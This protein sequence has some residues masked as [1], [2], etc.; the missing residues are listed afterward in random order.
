MSNLRNQDQSKAAKKKY[1]HP[2]IDI[3]FNDEPLSREQIGEKL[4]IKSDRSIR[5]IIA[6]CSM[7]YPIIATSDK[8]GY[9]RAKNMELLN[10]EELEKEIQEVEHQIN[11]LKSRVACL[12]KRM[13]PLVAWVS[14]AKKRR[15]PI[16]NE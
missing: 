4:N 6:K 15:G 16:E 3:L 14:I 13:K 8:K 5:D 9:R 10:S 7:H 12:K 11:E 2:I 1:F